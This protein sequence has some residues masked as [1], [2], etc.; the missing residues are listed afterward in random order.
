LLQE[1]LVSE[2]QNISHHYGDET[3]KA[4]TGEYVIWRKE[5]AP[6]NVVSKTV[7]GEGGG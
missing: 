6:N 3:K 5:K 1:I 2:G 4:E 7:R